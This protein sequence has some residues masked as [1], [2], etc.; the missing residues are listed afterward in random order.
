MDKVEDGSDPS[1]ADDVP[2]DTDCFLDKKTDV[3][4]ELWHSRALRVAV[5]SMVFGHPC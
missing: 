5:V 2:K 3:D 4:I 1:E